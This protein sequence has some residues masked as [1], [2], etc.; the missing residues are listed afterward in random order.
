MMQ[1]PYYLS[2]DCNS[3]YFETPFWDNIFTIYK[4]KNTEIFLI[5][6]NKKYCTF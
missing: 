5:Y 1:L 4:N 2:Y 6:N 3:M